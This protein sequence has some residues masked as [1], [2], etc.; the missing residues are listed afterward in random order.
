MN[1]ALLLLLLT[2][3]MHLSAI[4]ISESFSVK[5][6]NMAKWYKMASQIKSL[7]IYNLPWVY[8]LSICEKKLL[9]SATALGDQG[10]E[11]QKIP[12][13][14]FSG[15]ISEL[16]YNFKFLVPRLHHG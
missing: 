9:V 8:K 4:L 16:L 7:G 6:H 12:Q 11:I 15:R 14:V 10:F 3:S 2:L 1:G 5:K 13:M